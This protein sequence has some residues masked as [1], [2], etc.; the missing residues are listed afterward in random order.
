MTDSTATSSAIAELE[1]NFVDLYAIIGVPPAASEAELRRCIGK[2]YTEAQENLDHRSF[3]KRFYYL[4]LYEVHLPHAH[5]ALLNET[6]R[7]EY[8]ALR[9]R[10][11]QAKQA[12]A[13][14][15]A[16][17]STA[18]PGTSAPTGAP[19]PGTA[20]RRPSPPPAS[21]PRPS[22]PPADAARPAGAPRHAPDYARMDKATVERRR[23]S[24][25]RELIKN[26]LQA[27]G[28]R[29]GL[30]VG[31]IAF[32]VLGG[33]L[34]FGAGAAGA[35]STFKSVL[36]AAAAGAAAFAARSASRSARRNII[37][38]LSQMPYEEL[39]MRYSH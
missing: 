29:A 17:A 11:L 39:L 13:K 27:A 38:T 35:G 31:V 15:A 30:G 18:R 26:E 28:M 3:R 20:V 4:E 22:P 6:R 8:D 34:F 21:A 16:P 14:P 25:R 9:A 12:A 33:I 23:D 1:E 10:H 37:A 5:N 24:N 36:L 7:A 19:K 32:V 2:L